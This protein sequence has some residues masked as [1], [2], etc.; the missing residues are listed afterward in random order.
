MKRN[1]PLISGPVPTFDPLLLRFPP[2]VTFLGTSPEP[3]ITILWSK[4]LPDNFKKYST[5]ISI[6][7]SSIQYEN[8][9]LMKPIYGNDYGISCCVSAMTLGKQ[10]QFFGAR[11]NLAKALLYAIN[12]GIDEITGK[13]VVDGIDPVNN[14]ILKYD[15]VMKN[16]EKTLNIV[17]KTYVDAMNVIH[18]MHDKYAYEASQMALHDTYVE[19]LMAFGIAGLS[20]VADSLSAIKYAKVKPIRNEDGIAIDFKITGNYPK[21]GNDIDDVD[22]LAV[23]IVTKFKNMLKKNKLYKDA[24]HTLSV[25]TIT[26]NIVYGKKTGSTP[27]GRKK[28]AQGAQLR[29]LC[30]FAA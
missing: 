4:N 11:C 5:K 22:K 14:K 7:T 10:M 12:G 18:Y 6:L 9:D 17:A 24:I 25:L 13:K 27:D 19:K 29:R 21:Y 1:E 20:V 16:Y 8:D 26:S 2:V 30:V 15:E 3:N 28:G 23:D